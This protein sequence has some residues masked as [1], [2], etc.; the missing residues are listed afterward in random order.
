[1][2]KLE[3]VTDVILIPGFSSVHI[4]QNVIID[5]ISIVCFECH[6]GNDQSDGF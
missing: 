6:V 1:M 3:L 2:Y 5:E 4:Q